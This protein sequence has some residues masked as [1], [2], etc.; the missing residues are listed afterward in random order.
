[1]FTL[2]INDIYKSCEEAKIL[3][4]ADDTA[5]LYAAS[6]LEELQSKISRSFPKI[7][8]WLHADRLSLYIAK[9]FC[10]IYSEDRSTEL[11]ISVR[12]SQ[13]RRASAAKYLGVLIDEDLKLKSHFAKVTGPCSRTLG[14]LYRSSYHLNKTLLLLLYKNALIL[15]QLSYCAV[16]W[17][18]NYETTLKLLIIMQKRAIRLIVGARPLSH[19]S[20]LFRELRILKLPDLVNYQILLVMHD[21]LYERLPQPLVKFTRNESNRPVRNVKHFKESVPGSSGENILNY[22]I[23]NYRQF[24]LF[25]RGPTLWNNLIATKMP[26]IKDVPPSKTLFEKCIKI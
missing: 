2:Y 10:Q 14:I 4:F 26:N 7:S 12:N 1:M 17:G 8:T 3:L 16:I 18:S 13:L 20:P 9:T 23:T 22:R 11:Q 21:Y 24:V 6:T 15:P 25:C 19:I 5:V